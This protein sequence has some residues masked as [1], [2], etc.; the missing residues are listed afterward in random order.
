MCDLEEDGNFEEWEVGNGAN[1]N[2][3][4]AKRFLSVNRS[5]CSCRSCVRSFNFLP[6]DDRYKDERS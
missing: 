2:T 5:F 4:V 6:K 1:G 3:Q